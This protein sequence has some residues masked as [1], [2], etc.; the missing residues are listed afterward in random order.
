METF[1]INENNIIDDTPYEKNKENNNDIDE[2]I[3]M[4]FF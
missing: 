1:N 3:V 4:Y 2:I